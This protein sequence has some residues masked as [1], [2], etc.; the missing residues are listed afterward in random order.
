MISVLTARSGAIWA[1]PDHSP[2]GVVGDHHQPTGGFDQRAVG[3]GFHQ[4][5][6]GESGVLVDAV[7]AHDDHVHPQRPDRLHRNGSDQ[8]VGRGA[9]TAGEHDRQVGPLLVVQ[10]LGHLERVGHHGQVGHAGEVS[11]QGPRG[12]AGGDRDRHTRT[13][14]GSRLVRRSLPSR[15]ARG[16]SSPRSPG[17]TALAVSTA[18]APPCTL[19]S[20]PLRSRISRS[21]RTVMSETPE[22]R[23]EVGDPDPAGAAHLVQDARL[24]DLSEHRTG[25]TSR[26]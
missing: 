23:R 20:R 11:G 4:V 5:R 15:A 19:A 10:H 9:Q 1:R 6:G 24:A 13:A 8:T 25:P 3:L 17:S 14:P 22:Q 7:H 12:G 21:R 26:G 18:V 16:R 2:L